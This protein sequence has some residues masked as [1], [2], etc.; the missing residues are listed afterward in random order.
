MHKLLSLIFLSF[1]CAVLFATPKP[2]SLKTFTLPTVRVVV[3]KPSE[4]IGVLQQ[5]S[6]E[7]SKDALSLR[8][9]LQN[10]VG[11]S[12]SVGSK[13]ESNLRLRGFRKNE[14]KVM[15]DGRPI[16]NGYFGNVD[17]S[18][19]SIVGIKEIQVIKGPASPLFGNGSMGGVINL[20]TSE[21]SLQNRLTISTGIRRNNTRELQISTSHSYDTWN[22]RLGAAGQSSDGFILSQDFQPTFTENGSVRNFS[23]KEQYNLSSSINTELFTFHKLG[24]DIA[25]SGMKRKQIPS[26]IY[27]RKVRLYKDWARYNAGIT[28]E[29]RLSENAV[30][31]SL[32]SFD[33]G[34]DRYLE[35]NDV[36]MQYLNVDSR[37]DNQSWGWAPKLRIQGRNNRTIDLGYRIELQNNKRKDNG[38]YPDWTSSHVRNHSVFG[39]YS[40]MPY[41]KLTLTTGIGLSIYQNEQRKKANILAE[42]SLG[43]EYKADSGS[44][45]SF[46]IGR[47]SASPTMHQLFSSGKG[48]PDLLPQSSVKVE[49]SHVQPL[50]LDK[51]SLSGSVFYHD[52]HD[53][54]ELQ[55]GKYKNINK[56]ISEGAELGLILSPLKGYE[57]N[58][59]YSYLEYQKNSN[60]RL[61]ETPKNSV[62]LSHRIEL[63]LKAVLMINSSY[64]DKRLSQD[65]IG[66]Y[67]PLHAYWRHDLQLQVP[68]RFLHF[69]AGMDNIFDAD[70]QGEYGFPEAGRDF[71][72]GIEARL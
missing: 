48:N 14:V 18:K 56:L 3:Q 28:G 59:A 24:F 52:T 31:T 62:E 58:A 65:D 4:A 46:A 60:Y 7:N 47:N 66:T 67:H 15:I 43:L 6:L 17:I 12:A 39:Q 37:M 2:D 54:I 64:R 11:I 41:P 33:G 25:Y 42:P 44:I 71:F 72:F 16:N 8:D 27:E 26:S 36:A 40:S 9:A 30:L 20:I 70:Y 69:R 38:A 29:F 32:L 34:G 21:P 19:L 13:D 49:L 50:L 61:T 68:Y 35:Y 63:P 55:V 53:L 22:Y 5:L 1:T 51:L 57:F 10:N 45:S 23:A